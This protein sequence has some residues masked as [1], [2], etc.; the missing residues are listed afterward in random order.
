L[1]HGW[2]A[3]EPEAGRKMFIDK[4]T[5]GE[6]GWPVINNGTPSTTEMTAPYI[7]ASKRRE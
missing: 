3:T 1:Y 2:D 4:V 6:D 5:W 7:K